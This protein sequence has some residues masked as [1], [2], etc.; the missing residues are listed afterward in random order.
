LR[1]NSKNQQH[2]AVEPAP[3]FPNLFDPNP[4]FGIGIFSDGQGVIA[5][6]IIDADLTEW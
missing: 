6:S 4:L 2:A 1:L 3:E 5:I